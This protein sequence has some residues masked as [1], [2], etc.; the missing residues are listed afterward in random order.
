MR[1]IH[2]ADIEHAVAELCITACC[3]V[4]ADVMAALEKALFVEAEGGAARAVLNQI[5]EN[6]KLAAERMRPCCQDT[7]LAVVFLDVG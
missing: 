4:P 3:C 1:Y 2:A 7:G 5:I 6:H